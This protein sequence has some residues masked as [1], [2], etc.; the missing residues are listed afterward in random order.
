M[1]AP[2]AHFLATKVYWA[3][4]ELLEANAPS[5][6]GYEL[7]DIAGAAEKAVRDAICPSTKEQPCKTNNQ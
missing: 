2:D 4:Y 1:K 6:H 7:N 5:L 3:V